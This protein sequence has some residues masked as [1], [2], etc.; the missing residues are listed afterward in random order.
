MREK[1]MVWGVGREHHRGWRGRGPDNVECNSMP[2]VLYILGVGQFAR[3]R[4]YPNGCPNSKPTA[5]FYSILKKS[6][7]PTNVS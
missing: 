6:T 7:S 5:I 4:A 1:I 2:E 3:G